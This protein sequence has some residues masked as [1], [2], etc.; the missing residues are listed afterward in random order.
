MSDPIGAARRVA[1]GASQVG[2]AD[3]ARRF[4]FDLGKGRVDDGSSFGDTL[5][6]AINSVSDAQ[7]NSADHVRKFLRGEPVELHQVMAASSEAG[8]ALDLL[9]EM[10][11]KVTDAFRTL[12]NMQS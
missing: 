4:E 9:V 6:R 11:N 10:R 7:D 12:I 5:T 8:L 1:G 3:A 2:G